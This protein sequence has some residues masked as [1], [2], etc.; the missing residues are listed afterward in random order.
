MEDIEEQML[1]ETESEDCLVPAMGENGAKVSEA[2]RKGT[3][4]TFKDGSRCFCALNGDKLRIFSHVPESI[5][6]Q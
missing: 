3:A 6:L 2:Q 5:E 1:K 4:L